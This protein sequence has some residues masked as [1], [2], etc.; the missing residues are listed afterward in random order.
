MQRKV[1]GLDRAL[2]NLR[3]VSLNTTREIVIRTE[4][5]AVRMENYS[6]DNRPWT[7]R[8]GDARRS[9]YAFAKFNPRAFIIYHGIGVDYGKYLE[10]SNG[11]KY[12]VLLPTVNRFR[13]TFRKEIAGSLKG[14]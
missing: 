11:G 14:F 13:E 9:I 3:K 12:R 2:D 8:T 1:V 6:K 10:L 7:D 4:V 5:T